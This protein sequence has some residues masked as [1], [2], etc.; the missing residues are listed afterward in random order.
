MLKREKGI[1]LIALVV[2]IVVLIILAV[3][4]ISVLNG[5]N[6]TIDNSQE[7]R[8]KTE[9]SQEAEIVKVSA[10]QAAAKSNS[11]I[12]ERENLEK[13]LNENIGEGKYTLTEDEDKFIIVFK[14]SKT[15]TEHYVEKET[16]IE[17]GGDDDEPTTPEEPEDTDKTAPRVSIMKQNSTTN[18][19]TVKVTATDNE[20][21]MIEN[22]TYV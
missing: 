15:K 19:I 14:E 7:A 8:D 18:S 5:E 12:V 16:K 9:I 2:T 4:S 13:A 11:G 6:G 20:S 22:P 10:A 17:I 1:T 21:G 3:I